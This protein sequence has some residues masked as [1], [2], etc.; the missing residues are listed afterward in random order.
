MNRPLNEIIQ[1]ILDECDCYCLDKKHRPCGVCELR[2][3]SLGL[4][5]SNTS[6]PFLLELRD[7]ANHRWWIIKPDQEGFWAFSPLI[8]WQQTLWTNAHEHFSDDQIMHLQSARK[9]HL[10]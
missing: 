9:L 10:I 8:G 7:R 1:R 4:H 6:L 5:D 2:Q 3:F